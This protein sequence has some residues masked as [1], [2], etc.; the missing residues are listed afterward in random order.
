MCQYCMRCILM[1]HRHWPIS[2]QLPSHHYIPFILSRCA[3]LQR[4]K[5]LACPGMLPNTSTGEKLAMSRAM[6]LISQCCSGVPYQSQAAVWQDAPEGSKVLNLFRPTSSSY[7]AIPISS[8]W[9][10]ADSG[11]STH[12]VNDTGA[13]C[14]Q[15]FSVCVHEIYFQAWKSYKLFFCEC[16][17][18]S[19]SFHFPFLTVLA[20]YLEPALS[21]HTEE[22]SPFC[23]WEINTTE[24]SL[25]HTPQVLL[26]VNM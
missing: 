9:Y 4:E 21:S 20:T 13:D 22:L 14:K 6:S 3:H 26:A 5:T 1:P 23:S 12:V 18:F 8:Q 15:I 24:W 25:Q 19:Y 10:A 2:G 11:S 16:N 17:F 7:I